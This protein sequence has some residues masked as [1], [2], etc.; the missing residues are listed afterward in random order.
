MSLNTF[1]VDYSEAIIKYN[2]QLVTQ[3]RDFGDEIL[4]LW[5]PEED[6]I[7]NLLGII[8][9]ATENKKKRIVINIKR[10][11]IEP[12]F[13]TFRQYIETFSEYECTE[14]KTN[15]K[16]TIVVNNKN[17]LNKVIS[18]HS[19]S[20]SLKK[21]IKTKNVKSLIANKNILS[22]ELF[23]IPSLKSNN[24]ANL[25]FIK[26][27]QLNYYID[28][29]DYYHSNIHDK[30]L[31]IKIQKNNIHSIKFCCNK[32]AE[33]IFT[34][35]AKVIINTPIIEAF[36]HGVMKLE[37]SLRK[38]NINKVIP[39]IITAFVV[40]KIF[41]D[42]QFL[43][44]NIYK[45]Y[46]IK[47][48]IK[49][50]KNLYDYDLS[51]QWKSISTQEKIKK[52]NQSIKMYCKNSNVNLKFVKIEDNVKILIDILKN[53]R[54]SETEVYSNVL[55]FEKY[56]RKNIDKRLEVFYEDRPDD[57]KLRKKNL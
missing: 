2:Q 8:Y 26:K 42:Y 29:A 54:V 57:N 28:D 51:E 22:T 44:H 46:L 17:N 9:S 6:I 53:E 35:L 7:Q 25:F 15:Y 4:N 36:E 23:S 1:T 3:L 32:N 30:H 21:E 13:T 27:N 45:K 41:H 50:Y 39:G 16:I 48:N 24:D 12:F 31:F 47:N 38:K 37:N 5:V 14:T 18:Q 52:I 40:K 56:I 34:H 33:N 20:K 11:I 19:P 55:N 49:E 10:K 43:L